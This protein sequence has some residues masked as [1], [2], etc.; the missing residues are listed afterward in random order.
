MSK[1]PQQKQEA[2]A[3][4]LQAGDRITVTIKRLGING[5]GV[6]YYK[7][8]AVFVPGAL[9]DEVIKAKVSKTEAKYMEAELDKIE[10]RSPLRVSPACRV[11]EQCGGCQVQHLSPEGQRQAKE[12]IVRESFARYAGLERPPIRPIAA[13]DDPWGYRHKAQLQAGVISGRTVLGLYSPASHKLVDISGCPVQQNEI[14]AAAD[15][16]R[17]LLDELAIP[18]YREKTRQGVIRTV[19]IRKSAYTGEFQITFVIA[20]D[21][22]PKANQLIDAI[23]SRISAVATIAVSIKKG[24]S[25]L[26]FGDRTHVLWG[27]PAIEERLGSVSYQLSPRAFFQLNPEQTVKLYDFVK[28]AA[29]LSGTER[30][31]DAYCGTGT[32]ALWLAPDAAEVRGIEEIAEAVEDARNNA[33]RNR[34]RNASF[35][36]GK[37]EEVLPLWLKEGFRPDVIVADP[38]RTGLDRKLLSAIIQ[39]RP[40]RFV[41]VSCNPATLAKDC[42]VLLDGGFELQWIQPVDMFPQT[43]HVECV[44]RIYREE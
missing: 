12:E 41:Y 38:P 9:P 43:A 44:V 33:K 19:V 16:I 10:K 2:E 34:V 37:S 14:N 24:N 35:Y 8:K 25:P 30:V 20:A 15:C 36:V 3:D 7:R 28:E 13:M 17:S 39:A 32:I 6:G 42:K 18:P 31:V 4:R 26:V 1:R 29:A 23:V 11:Y 27:K 5:E 40:K 22:L 21:R